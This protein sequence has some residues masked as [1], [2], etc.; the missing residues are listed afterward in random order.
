MVRL[1]LI[2]HAQSEWN[3]AGRFQGQGGTGL[4]AAGAGQ[5]AHTARHLAAA[6]PD[7]ALIAH[8]DQERV[9]ATVAPLLALVGAPVIA[10]PRLREVDVPVWSGRVLADFD[11]DEGESL[12]AWRRG[13][14]TPEGAEPFAAVRARVGQALAEIAERSGAGV[15]LV[16]THGGAL[17]AGLAAVLGL[18]PGGEG[19]IAPVRNCALSIL[20]YAQGDGWRLV[21]HNQTQVPGE[22]QGAAR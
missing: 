3:A 9:V 10:D 8:S 18:P 1:V 5:A 6:Y 22:Q 19:R 14:L 21:A 16:F 15:A 2:R 13:E 12:A 11:R 20:D 7:V 4:S 17:R